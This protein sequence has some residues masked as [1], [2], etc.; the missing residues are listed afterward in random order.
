[1]KKADVE[2]GARYWANVAGELCI[3]RL[4]PPRPTGGWDAINTRTG[5]PIFVRS[6]QRLRGRVQDDQMQRLK[7]KAARFR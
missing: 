3:I 4:G 5:R 7:A 2:V 1:M 6:A